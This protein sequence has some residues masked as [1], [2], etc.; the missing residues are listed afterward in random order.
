MTRADMESAH[1]APIGTNGKP[2]AGNRSAG[3]VNG[4]SPCGCDPSSHDGR[5][6]STQRQG[7]VEQEHGVSFQAAMANSDSVK[8]RLS[9]PVSYTLLL[10]FDF[11]L[12]RSISIFFLA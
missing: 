1:G 3:R 11:F 7:G 10:P 4:V 5:S 8:L 2:V 12:V 9:S 6:V